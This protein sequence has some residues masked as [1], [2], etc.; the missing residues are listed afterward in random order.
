MK[1]R[2]FNG[3]TVEIGGILYQIKYKKHISN[4]NKDIETKGDI[5]FNKRIINI[6]KRMASSEKISTLI[7]ELIH[8][9]LETVIPADVSAKFAEIEELIVNPFSRVLTGALRSAGLL[10]E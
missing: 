7:H 9:S 6:L 1:N 2:R 4:S 3:K 5:D 10:K 8:G